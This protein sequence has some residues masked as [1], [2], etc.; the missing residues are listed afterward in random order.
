MKEAHSQK[1]KMKVLWALDAFEDLSQVQS[2]AFSVLRELNE[3]CLLE[4]EPIY[5]L[6]PE[7]LGVNVE[8]DL[9][10][11]KRYAP[12]AKKQ[13]EQKLKGLHLAGLVEPRVLIHQRPSLKESV[14]ALTK[15]AM[16]G[17]FDLILTGSHRRK[18]LDRLLLGSFAEEILLQSEVPVMV[19]GKGAQPSAAKLFDHVLFPTDF[20]EV[21][22][23]AFL[24]FL[25]FAEA[26]QARITLLNCI[27]RPA[28]AVFQSGIYLLSG[29]WISVPAF[30]EKE[31]VRLREEAEHWKRH[32]ERHQVEFELVV[33]SDSKSAVQSILTNAETRAVS[34]IAMATQ[35]GRMKSTLM[36]SVSRQVLRESKCPVWALRMPVDK[37]ICSSD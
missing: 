7:Q 18:G 2:E 20:S 12:P 29:G 10:W 8:F 14:E 3:R 32:A 31:Q 33:D 36:G 4:V 6:S 23:E 16:E 25:P 9:T 37:N 13:L 21:S 28:E 17:N 26:L 19:I 34:L 11:G 30:I 5:V 27:P 22:F 15:H 1:K 35:S 24:D